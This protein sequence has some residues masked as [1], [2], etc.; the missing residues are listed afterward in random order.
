MRK[1]EVIKLGEQL[2]EA[3]GKY[4]TAC[5]ITKR[6]EQNTFLSEGYKQYAIEK[7]Q[8]NEDKMFERLFAKRELI[9]SLNVD[10]LSE[11]FAGAEMN[12]TFA[13]NHR[14]E[15]VHLHPLYK[16]LVDG[17]ETQGLEALGEW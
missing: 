4:Y 14:L 11:D 6:I 10:T 16:D 8:N 5:N 7:A 2:G 13:Y 3:Y 1:N 12:K 17:Y 15:S 9:F